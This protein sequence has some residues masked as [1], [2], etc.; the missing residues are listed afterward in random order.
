MQAKGSG[1]SGLLAVS[2]CGQEVL[3]RTA[4]RVDSSNGSVTLRF[5]AGFPAH[6]RTIDAR[7]LEKMLFDILPG[8]VIS[9]LYYQKIYQN[10]L[11]AAIELC[12]DQQYIRSQLS[13]LGLCAFV[14]NGSVLPRQSGVSDRPMQ[15]AVPFRSP[16]SFLIT[17]LYYTRCGRNCKRYVT[18]SAMLRWDLG[19]LLFWPDRFQK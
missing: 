12:E 8:C 18:F 13:S 16:S 19:P 17:F 4:C 11:K 1:K 3:E 6:G 5:E 15:E 9:S 2:R 7:E 14:A 10:R